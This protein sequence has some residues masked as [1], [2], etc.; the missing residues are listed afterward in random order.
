ML[1]GYRARLEASEMY[2]LT[3]FQTL[4]VLIAS[5]TWVRTATALQ[6]SLFQGLYLLEQS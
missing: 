5:Y 6:L 3:I 1:R 2:T 4:N